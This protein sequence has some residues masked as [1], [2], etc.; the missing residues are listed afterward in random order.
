[1]VVTSASGVREGKTHMGM[2]THQLLSQPAVSIGKTLEAAQI[3]VPLF[4]WGWDLPCEG[5]EAS[6]TGG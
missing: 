4:S 5:R 3:S 1:M 2:Q 6:E